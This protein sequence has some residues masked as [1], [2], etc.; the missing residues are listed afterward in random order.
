M[1]NSD[2]AVAAPNHDVRQGAAA[3]GR[4]NWSTPFHPMD[5]A[6][7]FA[8]ES[9]RPEIRA[10][11]EALL[12]IERVHTPLANPSTLVF[13]FDHTLDE[14]L[15][16]LAGKPARKVGPRPTSAFANNPL[17]DYFAALEQALL[18]ALILVQAGR[19]A[20]TSPVEPLM[21]AER[22]AALNEVCATLR[23]IA[24]REIDVFDDLCRSIPKKALPAAEPMVEA[25]AQSE[26]AGIQPRPGSTRTLSP[27][28]EDTE[29]DGPRSFSAGETE[30][31]TGINARA[32]PFR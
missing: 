21:P 24:R 14:V 12:R 18:E 6:T 1:G 26:T 2:G 22:T 32:E 13:M 19:L 23:R 3:G 31:L 5:Q 30:T 17:R 8:L 29:Q 9:R 15:R 27:H 7:L 20:A 16:A 25:T 28:S 11:W 10:R 4:L